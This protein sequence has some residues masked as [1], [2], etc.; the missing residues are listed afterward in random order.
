MPAIRFRDVQLGYEGREPVL[1]RVDLHFAPGWTGVVGPNGAGKT[2]LV[3]AAIGEL[4]PS[5]GSIAIDPAMAVT[6][7]CEQ[8]VDEP[9]AS[10]VS[11]SGATD[12]TGMRWMRRLGLDP[13]QV[14]RWQTLSAGERKRWQLAAALAAEPDVLALDE[15]TNHLDGDARAVVLDAL[16]RFRGIGLVV[17]HDRE[18]LDEL[19]TQTVR[20]DA[21]TAELHDASYSRAREQWEADERV[22]CPRRWI[23]TL[24]GVDLRA[25]RKLV[26]RD[27]RVAVARDS[28]IH[29]DGRNGAGKS[30]LLAALVRAA[31]VPPERTLYVPQELGA[32]EGLAIAREIAALAP[33]VKGRV[34]QLVAALGLEPSRAL[35]SGMPSP[36]EAR[37]LAIALGLARRVWWVVLDEPTNHLDLPSIERLE[38]ALADY[39][40][41]LV[42]AS[43]DVRF[44][45]A[46]TR[47]RWHMDHGTIE[48]ADRRD[49]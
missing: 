28:R 8:R 30:T 34:G 35:A 32:S 15:P 45:E 48:S 44:A 40:G 21:R 7:L 37:K 46:V 33:D 29:V 38:A 39:P 23:A 3:R 24:D 13:F 11:L 6:H 14:D 25:G 26:A 9:S 19:T 18:L 27:V 5:S 1:D 10:I 16:R 20:V 49:S 4:A 42:L 47:E 2:T 31:S 36:G 22:P 12:R 41:A 43:H 17:S